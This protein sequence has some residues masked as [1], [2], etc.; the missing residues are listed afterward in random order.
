M[1]DSV[2]SLKVCNLASSKKISRK[3]AAQPGQQLEGV[4]FVVLPRIRDRE[5]NAREWR[6]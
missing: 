2:C 3:I 6:R 5:Q 1:A 4:G